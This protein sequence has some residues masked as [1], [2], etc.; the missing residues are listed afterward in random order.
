[1]VSMAAS[2]TSLKEL[3]GGG[4]IQRAG[5]CGISPSAFVLRYHSRFDFRSP[6]RFDLAQGHER[7]RMV[8][9]VEWTTLSLSKGRNDPSIGGLRRGYRSQ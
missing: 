1:M 6:P 8:S 2:G 5:S 7:S 4:G 9:N 3:G